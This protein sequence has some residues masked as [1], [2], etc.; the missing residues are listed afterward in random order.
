MYL[1]ALAKGL[2]VD[3]ANAP[4]GTAREVDEADMRFPVDQLI[5]VTAPE[6]NRAEEYR[7]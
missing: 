2:G 3:G 4:E 7:R 5:Y 6:T 1:A